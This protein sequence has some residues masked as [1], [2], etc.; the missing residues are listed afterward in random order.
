VLGPTARAGAGRSPGFCFS[1]RQAAFSLA[2]VL[3]CLAVISILAGSFVA[4]WRDPASAAPEKE[5]QSLARWFS[6]LV[7]R[8]N[9]SGRLFSLIC[10]DNVNQNFVKAEW[11]NPSD[12]ETYTSLYNCNFVRYQ[13]SKNGSLYTPQWNALVPTATIKVSRGRAEYF[14]VISQHGRARISP[15]PPK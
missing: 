8:S 3:I 11:Q 1:F 9:R 4:V 7:T 12:S 14:V 15:S 5:A 10:A 2:E 6:S 13:S